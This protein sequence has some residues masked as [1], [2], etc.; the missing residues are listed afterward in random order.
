MINPTSKLARAYRAAR[1][2][3]GKPYFRA[4]GWQAPDSLY[5]SPRDGIGHAAHALDL[6]RGMVESPAPIYGHGPG[7]RHYPEE[8]SPFRDTVPAHEIVP[9]KY[10]GWLTDP[11]GDVFRDGHGLCWGVV[12]QLPG[13][14]GQCRYVAGF[15]LGGCDGGPS[16]DLFT[17]YES[18]NP[19]GPYQR[20]G[21]AIDAARAAD[22]MAEK[23]AEQ[24][25][26]YQTAWQA[27][28][29]WATENEK[30]KNAR[31][32]V[33]SILAERHA[34]KARAGEQLP[35]ICRAIRDSVSGHL[36]TIRQARERMA[37]LA[38]GDAY[39]LIFYPSEELKGA[40]CEAA[41]LKDYPA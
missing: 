9:L 8:D 38:A 10:T 24:E 26:E 33:K 19:G 4:Q 41:G 17:I 22:S 12:C 32:A 40:F 37:E 36:N 15:Q 20:D 25:R 27:G 7:E 2:G 29:Q 11:Y 16:L 31:R 13:K 23:A 6:A 18:G 5:A 1:A 14:R 28:I 34:A 3:D 30:A 35:A 39:D 21:A